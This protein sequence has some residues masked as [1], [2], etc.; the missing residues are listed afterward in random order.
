MPQ[1]NQKLVTICSKKWR[2]PC[3]VISIDQNNIIIA[4]GSYSII[5]LFEFKSSKLKK[6]Q[7]LFGHLDDIT[8]LVFFNKKQQ[9][10]S[11]SKDMQ[12]IIWS[13]NLLSE[14]KKIQKLQGHLNYIN[15]LI[16]N[17]KE[18]LIISGCSQII[19]WTQLLNQQSIQQQWVYSQQYQSDKSIFGLSIN[20]DEN[21][22]I[23]CGENQE[24]LIMEQKYSNYWLIKQKIQI[25]EWGFRICF[26]NNN[27]FVFQPIIECD[28]VCLGAKTLDVYT[29]N[30]LQ[31]KYVKS[32]EIEIKGD[33]Q[34]C[35]QYFPTLYNSRRGMLIHK[36]GCHLKLIRVKQDSIL[37]KEENIQYQFELVEIINFGN[38]NGFGNLIG[39]LSNDG[40]NLLIW[41]SNSKEINIIKIIIQ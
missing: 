39:T 8:T 38:S 31:N 17:R 32:G 26:I 22:V 24:I 7:T 4:L 3:W 28:F 27:L 2:D 14:P 18:D 25:D 23:A 35:Y 16:L 21:Q 9:L 15:C 36:N 6:V 19:F 13:L 40:E 5:H 1:L 34:S 30:S 20:D 33:C 41:D 12:I 29:F 10:I 37:L 11:G